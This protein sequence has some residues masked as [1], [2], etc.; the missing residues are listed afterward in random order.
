MEIKSI[1]NQIE[2]IQGKTVF[3]RVDF[4]VP[5]NKGKITEERKIVATLPTI[6]FL[7]RN[8]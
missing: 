3:L 8:N 5:L 4:N 7:L 2:K 6:R 1:G